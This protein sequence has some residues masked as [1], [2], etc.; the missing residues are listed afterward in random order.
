MLRDTT[1]MLSGIGDLEWKC[2]KSFVNA[3][4]YY[5][6]APENCQLGKPIVHNWWRKRPYALY[7]SCRAMHDLQLWCRNLGPLLLEKIE[8]NSI[9]GGQSELFLP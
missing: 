9:N 2:M 5:S 7:K 8:K 4:R 1:F 6:L 3:P